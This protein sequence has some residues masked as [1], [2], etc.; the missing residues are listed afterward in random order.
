MRVCMRH[1][2]KDKFALPDMDVPLV[3]G[4]IINP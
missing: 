1:L 3:Y 4:P 2:I